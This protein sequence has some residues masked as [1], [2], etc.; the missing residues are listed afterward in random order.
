MK[1]ISVLLVMGALLG[2]SLPVRAEDAAPRVEEL[3]MDLSLHDYAGDFGFSAGVTSPYML[4]GH[5]AITLDAGMDLRIGAL[6]SDPGARAFL[7]NWV[8]RAGLIGSSGIINGDMR[9]YGHGGVVFILPDARLSGATFT[10]GG[11]G[12]FGFEFFINPKD[13]LPFSYFIELGS[14]G[15]VP[16]ADLMVAHPSF[17]TGFATTVGLKMY[18]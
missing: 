4:W 16:I 11:F 5:L 6:E 10:W 1:S 2:A 7:P 12:A 8:F 15:I 13:A 18:L 17:L 14:N 3:S 9:L